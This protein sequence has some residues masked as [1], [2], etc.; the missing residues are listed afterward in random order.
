MG[1][2]FVVE[3]VA[4]EIKMKLSVLSLS[5]GIVNLPE[6]ELLASLSKILS[7]GSLIW[8]LIGI[9][10]ILITLFWCFN[11]LWDKHFISSTQANEMI[12]VTVLDL[13]IFGH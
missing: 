1:F 8:F 12:R 10:T 13:L 3:V 5:F 2:Y 4:L 11:N 6:D 7:I 9:S